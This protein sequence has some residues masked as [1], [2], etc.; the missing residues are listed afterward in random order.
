MSRRVSLPAR[1]RVGLRI[2][3][4]VAL[5]TIFAYATVDA[6]PPGGCGAEA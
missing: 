2:A 3:C 6:A 1:A 4:G 5:L